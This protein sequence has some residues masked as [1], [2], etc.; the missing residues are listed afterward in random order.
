MPEVLPGYSGGRLP[1]RSIEEKGREEGEVDEGSE[2]RKIRNEIAQGVV[3]SIKDK[4]SALDGAMGAAQRSVWQSVMRSWDCS[5]I[6]NEG[7]EESWRE[8]DQMVG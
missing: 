6:E 2:E 4:A 3:A 5:Q 7:E 8:G 1:G